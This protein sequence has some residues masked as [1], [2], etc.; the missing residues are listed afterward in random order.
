MKKLFIFIL[1]PL[2]FSCGGNSSEKPDSGNV[3]ENFTFSM[4]TVWVDSKD[5][6]LSVDLG[7]RTMTLAPGDRS[8]Y[9]YN[10][11]E[12]RLDKID[13][14]SYE[15]E[16][17]IQFANEGPNGIGSLSIYDVHVTDQEEFYISSFDG[18]RKMD[19]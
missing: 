6:L 19:S 14:D 9:F 8:L 12:K 18:I 11:I 15:L 7:L 17:S 1:L 4:D 16:R 3:L 13:L 10:G 2:I 5:Q